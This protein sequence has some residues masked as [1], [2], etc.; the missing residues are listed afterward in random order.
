MIQ[1]KLIEVNGALTPERDLT[2]EEKQ[3][4]IFTLFDGVNA[5]YYQQGDELPE[6][7]LE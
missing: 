1:V 7:N 2:N 5:N 4:V 6:L 3:S